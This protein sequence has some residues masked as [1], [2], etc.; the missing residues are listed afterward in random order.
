M[1]ILNKIATKCVKQKFIVLQKEIDKT[2]PHLHLSEPGRL[3]IH[4]LINKDGN[5]GHCTWAGGIFLRWN[6][7]N[8]TSWHLHN[9]V[10]L[11]KIITLYNF[12]WVNFMVCKL[13]LIYTCYILH[14]C[15]YKSKGLAVSML[16]DKH[17]RFTHKKRITWFSFSFV[18]LLAILCNS[19]L[20]LPSFFWA[21]DRCRERKS[22]SKEC[23]ERKAHLLNLSQIV[24][25]FGEITC[26]WNRWSNLCWGWIQQPYL[27]PGISIALRQELWGNRDMQKREITV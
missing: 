7:L 2:T 10:H 13:C 3:R 19:L 24:R 5:S 16:S 6:V 12:K 15:I 26:E 27:S 17:H 18:G 23:L 1:Y 9:F 4:R 21:S 22:W 20:A 25:L 8:L 11:L 14:I